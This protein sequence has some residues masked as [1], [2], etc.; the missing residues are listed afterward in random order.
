MSLAFIIG[1]KSNLNFLPTLSSYQ[2]YLHLSAN[3]VGK[4]CGE[5]DCG[6]YV[7]SGLY[8]LQ[9][10]HFHEWVRHLWPPG[11]VIISALIIK[12]FGPSNYP[13]K[14]L[15]LSAVVWALLFTL[16]YA[17]L[18]NLKSKL[19]KIILI[20]MPL[21]LTT[22]SSWLFS[23]GLIL[24]ENVSIP[25][26]FVGVSLFILWAKCGKNYFLIL[27]AV[28]FALCAYIRAYIEC[29]GSFI[30]F[31]M[32]LFVLAKLLKEILAAYFTGSTLNFSVLRP[33][34]TKRLVAV[35][36]AVLIYNLIL[37]P[38][39]ISNYFDID[40]FAWVQSSFAWAYY[41]TPSSTYPANLMDY[42]SH[43]GLNLPCQLQPAICG[44]INPKVINLLPSFYAQM[45]LLTL[46]THP[47]QWFEFKLKY[48]YMFWYNDYDSWRDLITGSLVQFL[49][50]I[51]IFVAG[52]A[53]TIFALIDN[54]KKSSAMKGLAWFSLV[55]IIFNICL[56]TLVH[57][58][59]RYSLFLQIFFVYLPIWVLFGFKS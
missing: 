48:M 27:S 39:R 31:G 1:D 3:D 5:G 19:I 16:L 8:F 37:M 14:M 53:A 59:Y 47:V 56:F 17:S 51:A 29:F 40:S 12:L 11:P 42:W 43:A 23:Y 45:T 58:E 2:F 35:L 34:F 25:L 24:S 4:L 7:Q 21:Y 28:T 20:P 26:F 18:D 10:G 46:I 57:Y 52:I 54:R 38:W 32:V 44:V 13:L 41:W 30:T 9:T 36:I 15:C 6:T 22:I 50:G 49:E 33:I 55:L